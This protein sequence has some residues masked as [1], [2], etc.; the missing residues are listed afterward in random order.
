IINGNIANNLI[1]MMSAVKKLV[2]QSDP[3]KD[4]NPPATQRYVLAID[5]G[6][7]GPK[8]AVVSDTGEVK[9]S[10]AE[11][12]PIHTLPR[13]GA[14]QEPGAWWEGV[15]RSARKAVSE[16]RVSPDSIQAVSC[17]SQWSVVLPI[18]ENGDPLINEV[19]WLDTRGARDNRE[20]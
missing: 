12:V 15:I 5:L 2:M 8:A 14:E 7:G 11:R 10:A 6:S 1:M 19:H 20:G 3:K 9:S 13:G 4:D 17:T 16:S 18:D